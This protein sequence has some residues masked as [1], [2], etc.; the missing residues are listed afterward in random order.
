VY[1]RKR[2]GVSERRTSRVLGQARS[3][4]RH[5]PRHRADEPRLV[6]RIIAL[7]REY[8]RYG[9]CRITALLRREGWHVN[10]KRVERIWHQKGLKVPKKQ[11][12]RGRLWLEDGSCIR[13]D[14][15]SQFTASA[16]REWL[17]RPGFETLFI[18]PGSLWE[19]GYNDD[20]HAPRGQRHQHVLE[21]ERDVET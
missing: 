1:V 9:C 3:T 11:P 12:K 13:S 19:N 5:R 14:N 20:Q 18:A 2:L 10:A 15:G 16:V 7:A 21:Q 17:G 6:A 4:Q 8:G